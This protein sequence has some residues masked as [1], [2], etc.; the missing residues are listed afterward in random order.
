MLAAS[1]GEHKL[2]A[3][4]REGVD[5]S[6]ANLFHPQDELVGV[7]Q[8]L[9]YELNCGSRG[10]LGLCRATLPRESCPALLCY[11]YLHLHLHLQTRWR[12]STNQCGILFIIAAQASVQWRL[13][14]P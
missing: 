9:A 6:L 14:L 12:G 11:T 5:V 3:A 8:D 2:K 10:R 4:G 1:S 13:R 7:K